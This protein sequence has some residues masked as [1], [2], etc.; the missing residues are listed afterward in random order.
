MRKRFIF[1]CV[2]LMI[3][4]GVSTAFAK[5]VIVTKPKFSKPVKYIL[6]DKTKP[7]YLVIR[8]ENTTLTH[9]AVRMLTPEGKVIWQSSNAIKGNHKR[10]FYL[11]PD[12]PVY[13]VSVKP[14]KGSA[15]FYFESEGNVYFE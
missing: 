14:A 5:T 15:S 2:A 11:G 3:L 13:V 1:A 10:T 7:G 8:C 12:H 6:S 9:N 4:V